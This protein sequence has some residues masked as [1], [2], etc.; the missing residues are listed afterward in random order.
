MAS[1]IFDIEVDNLITA[2]EEGARASE[3]IVRVFIEPAIGTLRRAKNRRHHL[4]FGR[5]GSGKSSLLIK[6]SIDLA[7]DNYLSVYIDLEPFK[8]HTYPDIIISVLISVLIKLKI[9]FENFVV[10]DDK[11]KAKRWQFWKNQ[12][13]DREVE[14]TKIVKQLE[15]L[16]QD[17]ETKLQRGDI[18]K[19]ISSHDQG[20]KLTRTGSFNLSL[21]DLFGGKSDV[22]ASVAADFSNS[23]SLQASEEYE[24]SKKELLTA[25]ILGFRAIVRTLTDYSGKELF[26]FLDDLYHVKRGDQAALIDYFHRILKGNNG[27]LKIGTIRTRSEWY[28]HAPQPIGLKL[29]DDADE[30]NLDKTLEKFNSTKSFL[31]SVLREYNKQVNGDSYP[32]DFISDTGL[33]RLVLASGGVARDFLGLFRRSIFEA[34]ERLTKN[35]D[36]HRGGRLTAEDVNLASGAYGETKREEFQRDTDEDTK[37]LEDAFNK[38]RLFCIEVVKR[39]VFLVD[40]EMSGDDFELLEE[41]ID[42]RLIHQV[43]SRI[44]TKQNV[45]KIYRAFMLDVSQ[46]AGERARRDV[47]IL[48]FWKDNQKEKLR[49]KYMIYDPNWTLEDI[50][51]MIKEE[52]K[53]EERKN[54][55]NDPPKDKSLGQQGELF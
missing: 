12:K 28:R 37:A 39:N 14:R 6:S 4:I 11:P 26:L 48:E 10:D 21:K 55:K 20:K 29:G 16:L 41:L 24:Q 40:M 30:I 9:Y 51:G 47:E 49:R 36:H 34:R 3:D 32:L 33:D 46:Y 1:K 8:G 19:Y 38:V 50:R 52:Q 18:T 17:L 5:R 25:G 43:Q 27:F 45:G 23:S 31:R 53:T 7:E 42:L 15:A 44:T 2:T 13:S 22:E 54:R 35:P